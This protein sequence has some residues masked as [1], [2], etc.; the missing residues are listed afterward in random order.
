MQMHGC[1]WPSCMERSAGGR[2]LRRT[3]IESLMERAGSSATYVGRLCLLGPEDLVCGCP[4]GRRGR[5]LRR[6]TPKRS[7]HTA[8]RGRKWTLH[9][10]RAG[11]A[12]ECNA[13]GIPLST[14][15]RQGGW[16]PKSRV[17]SDRYIDHQCPPSIAGR[18]FF[19]W[20][21]PDGRLRRLG[22]S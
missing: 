14:I 4:R 12:S 7:N 2:S 10:I 22:A 3:A 9:C 15:R 17:P 13:L 16:G 6:R 11:P 1:G 21:T 18:R 5:D 20:L 19:D 8:T